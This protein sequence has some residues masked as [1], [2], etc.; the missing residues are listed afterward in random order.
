MRGRSCVA[1]GDAELAEEVLHAVWCVPL[2]AV[3][4]FAYVVSGIERPYVVHSTRG[5]R[6]L[7]IESTSTPVAIS[8]EERGQW[9]ASLEADLRR[10]R[11]DWQWTGPDIPREKPSYFGSCRRAEDVYGT[12][13]A[14]EPCL[15]GATS[16]RR[17][18]DRG[19]YEVLEPLE[20][21]FAGS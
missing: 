11:P 4:P 17:C 10:V 9:R 5:G 15:G 7:R 2:Y 1:A 18:A 20:V 13:D 19:A 21:P 12:R 6:P 8:R 16:R 14:W 3:S